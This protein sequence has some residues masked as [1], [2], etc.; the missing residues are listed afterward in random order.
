MHPIESAWPKSLQAMARIEQFV[1][2][3][4]QPLLDEV[5]M[6][7]HLYDGF[8]IERS[9]RFGEKKLLGYGCCRPFP[10]FKFFG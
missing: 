10:T 4:T 9:V 5:K 8:R 2:L 7:T 6:M 3:D 1:L